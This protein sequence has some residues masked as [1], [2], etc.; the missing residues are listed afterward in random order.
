MVVKDNEE[1][2]LTLAKLH[3]Y[4]FSSEKLRDALDVTRSELQD[5][6]TELQSLAEQMTAGR[7]RS[8]QLHKE[9]H[10]AEDLLHKEVGLHCTSVGCP[11]R[12]PGP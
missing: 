2:E 10:D 6:E 8:Q 3:C 5:A 1:V 11:V 9:L 4:E 7:E 12:A